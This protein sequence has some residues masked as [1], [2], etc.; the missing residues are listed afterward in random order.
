MKNLLLSI[1]LLSPASSIQ[2]N[3]GAIRFGGVIGAVHGFIAGY[4]ANQPAEKRITTIPFKAIE[5]IQ[6][7]ATVRV[8]YERNPADLCHLD[9]LVSSICS[10]IV[11]YPLCKI[12]AN[13]IF[14]KKSS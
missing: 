3:F 12:L 7:L 1:G 11:T 9:L 2:A 14:E 5:A 4:N 6:I 8:L 13:K 10:M